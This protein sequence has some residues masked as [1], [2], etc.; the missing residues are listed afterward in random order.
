[1]EAQRREYLVLFWE[2]GERFADM[3]SFEW[4]IEGRLERIVGG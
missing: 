1:M 3:A 4:F 2:L